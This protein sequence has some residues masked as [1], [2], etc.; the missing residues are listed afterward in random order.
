[1]VTNKTQINEHA[2]WR[3]IYIQNINISTSL[4][5][6]GKKRKKKRPSEIIC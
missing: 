6:K 4:T 2:Y 3:S 5:F 1:M